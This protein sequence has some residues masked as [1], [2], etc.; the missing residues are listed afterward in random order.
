MGETEEI[1]GGEMMRREDMRDEGGREEMGEMMRKRGAACAGLRNVVVGAA[2]G[3]LILAS[4]SGTQPLP[5]V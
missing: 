3:A 4:H 1:D 2:L 5:R